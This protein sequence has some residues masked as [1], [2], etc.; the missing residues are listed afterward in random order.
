MK[1][2]TVNIIIFL[3]IMATIFILLAA[4]ALSSGGY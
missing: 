4:S 3:G 1:E 2:E